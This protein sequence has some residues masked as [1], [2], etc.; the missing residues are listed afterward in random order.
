MAS[1]GEVEAYLDFHPFRDWT[2][3][4]WD[5]RS[6]IIDTRFHETDV[7]FTP[8]VGN[9]MVMPEGVGWDQY[10]YTGA[11]IVPAHVNHE[12]IGRYQ[13]MLGPLYFN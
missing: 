1:T 11:E 4:R 6:A 2:E 9:N 13:R 5:E 8:L 7:F 3:D 12:T 10:W